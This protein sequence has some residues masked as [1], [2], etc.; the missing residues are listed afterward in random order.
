MHL[1]PILLFLWVGKT[2]VPIILYAVYCI[3][4]NVGPCQKGYDMNKEVPRRCKHGGCRNLTTNI[5]G[6]C[7]QHSDDISKYRQSSSKRGYGYKWR[8]ARER[9]LQ[10]YPFVKNA[11]GRV[12]LRCLRPMLTTLCRIRGSQNTH[13]RTV[14]NNQWFAFVI[15]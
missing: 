10:L 3:G 1:F 7:D 4:T 11:R 2:A 9:H 6:Y 8:K 13:R 5:S 14:G 15:S 12:S